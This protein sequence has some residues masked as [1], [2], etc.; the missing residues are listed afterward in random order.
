MNTIWACIDMDT[1]IHIYIHI[2]MYINITWKLIW[3]MCCTTSRRHMSQAA[4]YTR[5]HIASLLKHIDMHCTE[6]QAP[7]T[8]WNM[9]EHSVIVAWP[10]A[11]A[12]GTHINFVVLSVLS[13]QYQCDVF[14]MGR[15]STKYACCTML[16]EAVKGF[17]AAWPENTIRYRLALMIYD[18]SNN[19]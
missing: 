7:G 1:Y 6:E 17:R 19:I 11:G 4:Y 8:C 9:A 3:C 2:H 15:H 18:A 13:F 16:P 12:L 14:H 5:S 10:R